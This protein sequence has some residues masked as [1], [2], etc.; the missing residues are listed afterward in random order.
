MLIP[1]EKLCKELGH[2]KVLPKR[3]HMTKLIKNQEN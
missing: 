2:N 1:I 3:E